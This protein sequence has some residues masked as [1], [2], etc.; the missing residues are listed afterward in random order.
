MQVES[1]ICYVRLI[2]FE[3]DHVETKCACLKLG[4]TRTRKL[5]LSALHSLG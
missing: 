3:A 2:M 4:G 5:E 1:R